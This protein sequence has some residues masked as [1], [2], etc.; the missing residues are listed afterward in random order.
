MHSPDDDIR[1]NSSSGGFI[2]AL[3]LHMLEKGIIN[4]AI[5]TSADPTE[6]LTAKSF[7]ASDRRSLLDAR[8][9]KYAPASACVALKTVLKQP[10]RYVFV[11][12][13]CAIEAL[14]KLKQTIKDLEERIVLTIALVCAGMASRLST[15][16]YLQR[17]NIRP[18]NIRRICYRGNGWPGSFR[19]YD[20][21]GLILERPLLGD[22]LEYLVPVDHYLRCYNCLD[23]WAHFADI[24]VSDPWS[25]KF[26]KTERKGRS[27]VM[28]KTERGRSAVQAAIDNGQLIAD[29]I[30]S[31]EMVSYNK[32]LVI[33]KK[34]SRHAWMAVYQILF[35]GRLKYTMRILKHLL[36]DRNIGLITT[37]KA[38]LN[39]Y[40]YEKQLK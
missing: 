22:E 30:S 1:L 3:I 32:H 21:N 35:F 19:A 4:G 27:A 6:P 28:I 29:E 12:T 11:A 26:I 20:E 10:G 37:L 16:A 14:T 24:A 31:Q 33:D 13:P 25:D 34:H 9:S 36:Y 5:V 15:K 8:A 23:H 40:Y 7:I 2:T 18:E 39:K 38:R 17:Y